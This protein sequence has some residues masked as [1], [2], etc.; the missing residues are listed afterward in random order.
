MN[1]GSRF[2]TGSL[3]ARFRRVRAWALGLQGSP[4]LW[5][6]VAN[7]LWFQGRRL[8]PQNGPAPPLIFPNGPDLGLGDSLRPHA[9]GSVQ[10]VKKALAPDIADVPADPV[11]GRGRRPHWFRLPISRLF[12]ATVLLPVLLAG[13][14][15]GVIASD[16]YISESKYVLRSP[17]RQTPVGLTA[18]LQSA[19]FTRAQDDT[20]TVQ[21]FIASRDA[22]RQLETQLGVKERFSSPAIDFLR[23]FAALD[24]DTSF[25]AFHEYFQHF[26][27]VTPDPLSAISTLRVSAF[28]AEDARAINEHLLLAGEA[29]VNKLNERG[30]QD[31]IRFAER[32]VR[33]AEQQTK[34]AMLALLE[35]RDRKE[36]FD[37]ARQSAVQL[38]L[39]SKLQDELI[40]TRTQLAQVRALSRENPQIPS[41]E[42]RART[43]QSAIDSENKKVTGGERSLSG[44]SGEFERLTLEREFA[45]RQLAT[46]M[47]SLEQARNDALRKQLY[48][49]RVAQP[50]LPDTALEPRRL[51]GF[52]SVLVLGLVSW[53]ILSMLI[54]GVREHRD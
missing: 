6:V 25:E 30:R 18:I 22:L 10:K 26:I 4:F 29:L 48:L 1:G 38:Q 34:D 5:H 47:A 39:I 14:Y 45:D 17:Q 40:L 33:Q 21:D 50:S 32:E 2:P 49:E 41:L 37:P 11:A 20:Y 54:A 44:K 23:R 51:R 53:G 52:L 31:L 13:L 28:T 3:V 36:V 8:R 35:F 27:Q 24:G 43:L 19:G 15:F 12:S 7:S 42:L 46:A 16:V 9:E